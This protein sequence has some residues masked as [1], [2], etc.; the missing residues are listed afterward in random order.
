MKLTLE[1]SHSFP[2]L[3]ARFS[4]GPSRALPLWDLKH[5]MHPYRLGSG[6]CSS[7][8]AWGQGEESEYFSAASSVYRITKVGK[9]F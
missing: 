5:S 9:D 8:S 6:G 2:R 3:L 4:A 7:L 1:S